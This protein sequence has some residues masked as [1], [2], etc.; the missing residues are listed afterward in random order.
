MDKKDTALSA[1]AAL[2][3]DTR[4]ETFRCLVRH[5]P[6]GL[7]AGVVADELDVPQNTLSAHLAILSRA[8]LVDSTR[9]GRSIVYQARLDAVHALTVFLLKD[10]CGAGA[11]TCDVAAPPRA[12]ACATGKKTHA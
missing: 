1:L 3:Q 12:K 4:L 9:H 10:C 2:A 11:A 6:D 5:A 7:P 8:G